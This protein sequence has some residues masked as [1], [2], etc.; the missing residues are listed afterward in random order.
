M[1]R[2]P[3]PA[4]D[5]NGHGRPDTDGRSDAA[6]KI[7]ESQ[8]AMG[9]ENATVPDEEMPSVEELDHDLIEPTTDAERPGRAAAKSGRDGR[10]GKGES[11]TAPTTGAAVKKGPGK[12]PGKSQEKTTA[13]KT[14]AK[15][16]AAKKT[17]TARKFTAKK[18]SA[19]KTTGRATKSSGGGSRS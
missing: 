6:V 2:L 7:I 1:G 11:G 14:T 4:L 10:R 15:K 8:K 18:T 5:W 13:K 12:G 19:G 16:A 3:I 17:T 9:D